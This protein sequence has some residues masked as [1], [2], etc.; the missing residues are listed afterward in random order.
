M[1]NSKDKYLQINEIIGLESFLSDR[2]N[3]I[4]YAKDI[5]FS[6]KEILFLEMISNPNNRNLRKKLFN[7]D[8][9]DESIIRK[10]SDETGY[11][12]S[13]ITLIITDIRDVLRDS[14]NSRNEYHE[15]ILDLIHI[16]T[17]V[18]YEGPLSNNL[19]NGKGKLI[20]D[21]GFTFEGNFVNGSKEGH[22][23]LKWPDGTM[24]DGE[25]HNNCRTE[26]VFIW[27]N[28]DS[29]EGA[30]LGS[31]RTGDGTY[32]WANGD[33]YEGSFVNNIPTGE[34]HLSRDDVLYTGKV[35][36]LGD[37][38]VFRGKA[39]TRPDT[40]DVDLHFEDEFVGHCLNQNK[41]GVFH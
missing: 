15:K 4:S 1:K 34:G 24:F 30:F 27:P 28:K 9:D 14:I 3:V 7:L 33:Y 25:Y 41:N 32:Y 38:I 31:L 17:G 6:K 5:G 8:V 19:P 18:R 11:D 36:I 2:N 12:V 40:I 13:F 10:I 37:R 23:V 16:L 39:D 20:G 22:G 26:G 29:Y 21:S 35:S